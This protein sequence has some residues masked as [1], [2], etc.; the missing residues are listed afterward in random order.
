MKDYFKLVRTIFKSSDGQALFKLW[1][2]MYGRSLFDPDVQEMAK[3]TG[4]YDFITGLKDI[5]ANEGKVK[6][7]VNDE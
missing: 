3:R 4:I 2:D 7:E 1:D 5:V 6:T